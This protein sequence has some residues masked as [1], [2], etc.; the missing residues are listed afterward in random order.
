MPL[1][2]SSRAEL[3][4]VNVLSS[5]VES[6]SVLAGAGL[7][8]G[9]IVVGGPGAAVLAFA[10]ACVLSTAATAPLARLPLRCAEVTTSPWPLEAVRREVARNE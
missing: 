2:T 9:L 6:V 5:W 10:L 4:A 8:G 7:A 3:T 1:L